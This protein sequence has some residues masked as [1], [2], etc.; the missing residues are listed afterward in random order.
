MRFPERKRGAYGYPL[1]Q[2]KLIQV[3]LDNYEMGKWHEVRPYEAVLVYG[4]GQEWS[5]V[6]TEGVGVEAKNYDDTVVVWFGLSRPAEGQDGVIA[7]HSGDSIE[8]TFNQVE[9]CRDPQG[10]EI[11][12]ADFIRT[13]G[14]RLERNHRLWWSFCQAFDEI[15]LVS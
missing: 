3:I 7:W 8:L 14:E 11:D 1:S 6:N 10:Q 4:K 9:Q 15:E 5:V 12:L 2:E 13:F